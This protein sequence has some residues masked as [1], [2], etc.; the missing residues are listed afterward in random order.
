MVLS[1][2]TYGYL[3]AEDSPVKEMVKEMESREKKPCIAAENEE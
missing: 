2:L 1:R 3:G